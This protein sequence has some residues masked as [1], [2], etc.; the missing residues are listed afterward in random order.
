VQTCAEKAC[1]ADN[2]YSQS[3]WFHGSRNELWC[4]KFILCKIKPNNEQRCLCFVS[5]EG[6]E[7]TGGVNIGKTSIGPLAF[8]GSWPGP[9][10]LLQKDLDSKFSAGTRQ[11]NKHNKQTTTIII[12]N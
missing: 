5:N 7:L 2:A 10:I 3:H 6:E 12:S 11:I 9:A 4:Q 1:K 8:F